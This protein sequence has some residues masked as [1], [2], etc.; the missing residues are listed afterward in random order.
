M[1]SLFIVA[2]ALVFLYREAV[3]EPEQAVADKRLAYYLNRARFQG[4][5]S[6]AA[7]RRAGQ[8]NNRH[9]DTANAQLPQESQAPHAG[10]VCLGQ[11]A[12]L[13]RVVRI[14]R[15]QKLLG[16]AK[17]HHSGA[18]GGKQLGQCVVD[19]LVRVDDI[20]VVVSVVHIARRC[21]NQPIDRNYG[22]PMSVGLFGVPRNTMWV[23]HAAMEIAYQLHDAAAR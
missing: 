6:N 10:Q 17:T 9:I 22:A 3:Q 16:A 18:G 23:A 20:Y 4:L 1:S 7:I 12:T 5:I 14:V 8:Y 13:Q 19:S 11:Y 21:R 2:S 15:S